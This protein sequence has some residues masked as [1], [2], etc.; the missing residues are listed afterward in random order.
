MSGI[1][2][3]APTGTPDGLPRLSRAAKNRSI[4]MPAVRSSTAQNARE[5]SLGQRMFSKAAGFFR[6]FAQALHADTAHR[7][8]RGFEQDRAIAEQDS[9]IAAPASIARISPVLG[10]VPAAVREEAA[11]SPTPK[12]AAKQAVSAVPAHGE[13]GV[14]AVWW[15]LLPRWLSRLRRA[16]HARPVSAADGILEV[17]GGRPMQWAFAPQAR[18]FAVSRRRQ[19]GGRATRVRRS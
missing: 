16:L 2:E 14:R 4:A 3:V 8:I 19:S 6:G 7:D 18:E 13:A 9:D 17:A 11:M 10:A 15:Q 5:A 1:L 12:Q